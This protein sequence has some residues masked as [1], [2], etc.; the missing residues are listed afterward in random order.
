M[1][2]L[3][4]LRRGLQGSIEGSIVGAFK[5]D[6]GSL[7]SS[8]ME[9][10]GPMQL[11]LACGSFQASSLKHGCGKRPLVREGETKEAGSTM[12]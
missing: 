6:A 8:G 1:Q 5:G 4:F 3:S 9:L 12:E 2:G 10:L 11:I 7:D